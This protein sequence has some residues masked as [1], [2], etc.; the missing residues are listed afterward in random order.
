M[1]RIVRLKDKIKG[2]ISS[3]PT[4][5]S[6]VRRNGEKTIGISLNALYNAMSTN[7]GRW[8]NKRFEVFYEDI[9]LGN[10]E[11]N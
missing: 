9:D 6:L 11:W 5:A 7:K 1:K 10:E 3:Y 2:G 8:S 4:I